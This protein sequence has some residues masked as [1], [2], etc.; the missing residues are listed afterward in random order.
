MVKTTDPLDDLLTGLKLFIKNLHSLTPEK[1]NDS[2]FPSWFT[3]ASANLSAH[4]LMAYVDGSMDVPPATITVTADGEAAAAAATAITINPDHEKW[5]VVDAQLRACLLAI[6]SPSVQ[7]HLHGLTSAAAIWNHLQLRTNIAHVTFAEVSSW[8]LT[9]EL[10][11]QMEQKLK[12][13]EAGGLAEPHTTLYAQS[14]QSAVHRGGRGRGFHRG[15]GGTPGRGSSAGGRGGAVDSSQQRGGYS[16]GRG[17]SAGRGS[18]P[19]RSS[20]ICQICGKYKHAAWDCWHR[21]DNTYFGPSTSSPQA[22]YA[23]NSAESND[24]ICRELIHRAGVDSC[25]TAPTPIS[26]SQSTN[27]A[28]VPFHNP[29]LFRSLVGD[30]QY[31]TVTRPDIQFTVNYVAQKMHSPMEQDFHTLKR[32]LRYV[33]GTI[34]CGIT[35]SRRDLRLRGYSDSD[36][37]NDPSDSRSTTG[38]LIFFGPN[39]ISVNTQKQGRVSKSSTEV[40]YRALSA[41]AS[42]VMWFTYLLADLH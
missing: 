2:N 28:D 22:F 29:R 17:G 31:L 42:E 30:L 34:L 11:V 4:R 24:Q 36:W 8:L 26:P 13:R 10:N 35:F 38:Y 1:L 33:K 16:G 40:E 41:A 18:G 14:W 12:V 32:I 23:A 20:I 21:F 19:P 6:I 27:G 7:N 37:A 3:T 9:E 15:R 5:S 39:L 25:T